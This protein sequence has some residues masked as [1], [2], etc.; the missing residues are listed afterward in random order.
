M[1]ISRL[2]SNPSLLSVLSC[3]L[4]L[5]ALGGICGCLWLSV[6]R[7]ELGAVFPLLDGAVSVSRACREPPAIYLFR[8]TVIPSAI[9]G[10][11]WWHMASQHLGH[12]RRT[13]V[14]MGLAGVTGFFIYSLA[15]G[16]PGARLVRRIAIYIFLA[17][18]LSA[19]LIFARALAKQY[20]GTRYLFPATC[21]L[22]LIC[23]SLLPLGAVLLDDWDRAENFA[24]W[25]TLWLMLSWFPVAGYTVLSA[26]P[27]R[28]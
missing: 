23:I 20:S 12:W 8:M 27:R 17:L 15:L 26:T 9:I 24:E 4:P 25:H 18:T 16:V 6:T 11:L 10:A 1:K 19:Q 14:I 13:V 2:E 22:P 5:L 3:L 21:A 28:Q 7:G